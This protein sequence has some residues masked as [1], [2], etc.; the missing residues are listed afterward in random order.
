MA[1]PKG[2]RSTLHSDIDSHSTGGR[3]TLEDGR[4]EMGTT[5][6]NLPLALA[7]LGHRGTVPGFAGPRPTGTRPCN[8]RPWPCHAVSV[9]EKTMATRFPPCRSCLLRWTNAIRRCL[10]AE[11]H[12]LVLQAFRSTEPRRISIGSRIWPLL[13]SD[14][15]SAISGSHLYIALA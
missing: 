10:V 8:P 7:S 4:L 5:H 12:G 9:E 14:L 6:R 1:S 15:F 3:L 11:R 13:F 2:S